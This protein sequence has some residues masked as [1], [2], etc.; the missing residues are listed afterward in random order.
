MYFVYMQLMIG[1]SIVSKLI[2]VVS[3]HK[4]YDCKSNSTDLER[5]KYIFKANVM[6][7]L[8]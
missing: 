1:W 2:G 4:I 3:M 7:V 5:Q 8:M 6:C